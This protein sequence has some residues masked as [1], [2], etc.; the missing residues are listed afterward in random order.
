M[1]SSPARRRWQRFVLGGLVLLVAIQLVPYGRAH[2]NPPSV[3]EPAWDSPETRD[4]ARAACFDCHSNQTVW[5]AYSYIAPTS[6]LVQWDVDQG[7]SHLNFT[8]WQRQQRHAKD[9]AEEVRTGDMPETSYTWLHS[10]ARL[11]AADR[12]RLAVAFE[13][14]FGVPAP[15]GP[16]K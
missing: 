4:L 15:A 3:Q 11:S 14:M 6:W 13:K 2:T 10:Q 1:A 9:A 7:R 5:P 8:E 16:P 12:Q